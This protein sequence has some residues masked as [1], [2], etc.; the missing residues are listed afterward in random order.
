MTHRKRVVRA[1]YHTIRGGHYTEFGPRYL[2]YHVPIR[3]RYTKRSRR[4]RRNPFL[5]N[6]GGGGS[7]LLL[8]GVIGLGAFFLL[9]GGVGTLFGGTAP[10]GYTALGTSGYYRGPDGQLYSRTATGG[11]ML[12]PTQAAPGSAVEAQLIAAGS[13]LAMPIIQATAGGLATMIGNL[14]SGGGGG[15]VPGVAAETVPVELPTGGTSVTSPDILTGAAPGSLPPLPDLTLATPAASWFNP[16][17][18]SGWFTTPAPLAGP[19]MTMDLSLTPLPDLTPI[20]SPDTA[21]FFG[22]AARHHGYGL[23][24]RDPS[25]EVEARFLRQA[26]RYN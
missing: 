24:R 13:R 3:G 19:T 17:D 10:A 20:P 6:P 12:S 5:A 26:P 18:T 8:F 16:P 21:G 11:M 25:G 15:V 22:F 7:R 9:R 23:V 1:R 2:G 4:T 14:F